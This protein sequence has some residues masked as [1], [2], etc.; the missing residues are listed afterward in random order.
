MNSRKFRTALLCLALA[1]TTF[2]AASTARADDVVGEI[3]RDSITLP[4][5]LPHVVLHALTT[6]PPPERVVIVER[7]YPRWRGPAYWHRPEP[8]WHGHEEPRA[9][10]PPRGPWSRR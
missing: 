4:L 8:R 7:G 10:Y 1:G 2:G 9:P 6:P 3:I 5:V